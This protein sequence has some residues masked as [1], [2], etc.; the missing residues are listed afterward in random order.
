[1]SKPKFSLGMCVA[2]PGARSLLA[3]YSKIEHEFI[4]R[5]VSG[6]WGDLCSDD[7][8]ANEAAI[9]DGDRVFS[10]YDLSP[11]DKVYVITEWDRSVTTVLL[12]EDY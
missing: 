7:K 5:H 3:K 2:T 6:D 1:M 9:K 8:A 10:S 4:E 12:P 11:R